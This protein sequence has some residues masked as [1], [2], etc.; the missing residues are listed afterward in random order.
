MKDKCPLT[1]LLT[2]IK[3]AQEFVSDRP[4]C[5]LL[6]LKA[7]RLRG[8]K[9]NNHPSNNRASWARNGLCESSLGD[10]HYSA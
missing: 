2:L 4:T 7:E 5:S 6:Y 9:V 8:N 1:S 3:L 10:P